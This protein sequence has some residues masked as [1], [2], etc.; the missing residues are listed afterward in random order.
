[1]LSISILQDS[2]SVRSAFG[3]LTHMSPVES[4]FIM[5]QESGLFQHPVMLQVMVS[6]YN[7]ISLLYSFIK[8]NTDVVANRLNHTQLSKNITKEHLKKDPAVS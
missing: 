4:T 3:L 7:Y 1:M 8:L 6:F 2:E 5:S